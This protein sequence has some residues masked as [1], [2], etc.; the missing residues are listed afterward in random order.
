MNTYKLLCLIG[1]LLVCAQKVLVAL[2]RVKTMRSA[3]DVRN[4]E[5][6]SPQDGYGYLRAYYLY[7]YFRD[8]Y[9]WAALRAVLCCS[10]LWSLIR[11]DVFAFVFSLGG[12][13]AG[14]GE[15]LVF[16]ALLLLAALRSGISAFADDRLC[17]RHGQNGGYIRRWVRSL[18]PRYAGALLSSLIIILTDMFGGSVS[19][20][21]HPA[22][23]ALIALASAAAGL[24]VFRF[25]E[26]RSRQITV[27]EDGPLKERLLRLARREGI[28]ICRIDAVGRE[29]D[30][31]AYNACNFSFGK[32]AHLTFG[33]PLLDNFGEDAALSVLAHELGHVKHRD[34]Q[35]SFLMLLA[36]YL[37]AFV[38]WRVTRCDM[39]L[40]S[41]FGFPSP[42]LVFSF[43]LF[44]ACW[45][46]VLLNAVFC[47]PLKWVQ[48]RSESRADAFAVDAG[49]GEHLYKFLQHDDTVIPGADKWLI[50]LTYRYPELSVR[51]A[52]I[53][54]RMAG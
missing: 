2:L 23:F 40:F 17:F 4:L 44:F 29:S 34:S 46:F 52:D 7:E 8:Y 16:D 38:L 43:A 27:L 12:G 41:A 1:L 25:F 14:I 21:I 22:L 11:F 49:L 24:L 18:L 45:Y 32:F 35:K 19:I 13:N 6:K 5:G 48:R 33:R 20:H 54:K 28:R 47:I 50:R 53:K 30:H 36:E 3:A 51:L 42:C 37:P 10:L 31:M 39:A 26:R 15:V 9:L